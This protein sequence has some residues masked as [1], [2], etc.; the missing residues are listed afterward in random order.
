MFIYYNYHKPQYS[1]FFLFVIASR[2][3][4]FIMISHNILPN[5]FFH[6]TK[7]LLV[8]AALSPTI[9]CAIGPSRRSW[10]SRWT[11]PQALTWK[12]TSVIALTSSQ[13]FSVAPLSLASELTMMSV[14]GIL[15]KLSK[16]QG[17]YEKTGHS[18]IFI[19]LTFDF[20]A[21]TIVQQNNVFLWPSTSEDYNFS[22][23]APLIW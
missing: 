18:N 11:P 7:I 1:P 10:T 14:S 8:G 17:V 5:S 21:R 20:K 15:K 12:A 16:I 9:T 3:G 2:L 4:L 6:L 22:I 13:A 23:W 19:Y